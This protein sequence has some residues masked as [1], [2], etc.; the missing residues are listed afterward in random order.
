MGTKCLSCNEVKGKRKCP[1]LN[2][3]ICS[4][5]CGTKKLK[6]INCPSDCVYLETSLANQN[7]KEINKAISL[8]FPSESHDIFKNEKVVEELAMPFEK[9]LAENFYEDTSINDTHIY[10][11][12][13]KIYIT[14][15][16]KE[17][18]LKADNEFEQKLI[19]G[20]YLIFNQSELSEDLKSKLIL[21]LLMSIKQISGG[22]FGNRNYLKFIYNQNNTI[23]SPDF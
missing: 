19:D 22:I 14:I 3:L 5:C 18:L 23:F 6:E 20:Y 15:T 8:T 21:R 17:N 7:R 1:A 9:F 2:G 12:L 13:S 16:N 10:E 11:T 4:V